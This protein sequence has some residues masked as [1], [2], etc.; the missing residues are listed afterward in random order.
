MGQ[1]RSF[2]PQNECN[3]HHKH[4]ATILLGSLGRHYPI[5]HNS[6]AISSYFYVVFNFQFL[7][8]LLEIKNFRYTLYMFIIEARL[9]LN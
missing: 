8:T 2:R 4:S 6:T 5:Q 7:L 3:G 9:K 1:I